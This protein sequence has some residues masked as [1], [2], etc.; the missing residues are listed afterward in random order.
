MVGEIILFGLWC[1]SG[2]AFNHAIKQH[3]IEIAILKR[4]NE[5]L[6]KAALVQTKK[7]A[8]AEE[9]LADHDALLKDLEN[10]LT[11]IEVTPKITEKRSKTVTFRQFKAAAESL[12][13][14][15]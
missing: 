8:K 13:E 4:E 15:D 10:R 1:F 3:K 2:W 12:P 9:A 5:S 6:A 11:S 14:E 7:L